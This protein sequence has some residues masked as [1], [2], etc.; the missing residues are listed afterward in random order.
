MTRQPERI[1]RILNQPDL[2]TTYA[3]TDVHRLVGF[4]CG[5]NTNRYLV[6]VVGTKGRVQEF[7][8]GDMDP[9]EFQKTLI[10]TMH[11]LCQ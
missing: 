9:L 8:V 10:S 2:Y 4:L 3:V 6:Q 7:P 11:T 5:K 1:Y